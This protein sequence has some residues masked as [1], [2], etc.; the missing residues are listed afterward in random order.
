MQTLDIPDIKGL[1]RE[2]LKAPQVECPVTHSFAPDVYLREIFMPAGTVV[3]G[4]EHK[5]EHLNIIL[6][7]KVRVIMGDEV[8]EMEAPCTFVSGAGVQKIVNV[9]EDCLWQTVHANPDNEQDI[10]TLEDRYVNKVAASLTTEQE[11]NLLG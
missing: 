1:T 11:R 9:L 7:G 8:H 2:F 10:E 6:S 5:T 4:H 3:I